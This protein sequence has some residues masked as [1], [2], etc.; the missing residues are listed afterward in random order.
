MVAVVRKRRALVTSVQEFQTRSGQVSRLVGV[1]Y[2]DA[3]GS[4]E[5]QLLWEREPINEV[6]EP[7]SPPNVESAPP[8]P[9]ADFN[10]V[11]RAA[12]WQALSPFV[13]ATDDG[14]SIR[15]WF[16]LTVKTGRSHSAPWLVPLT[17]QNTMP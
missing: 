16:I 8:M 17:S 5:D 3:D 13:H 12:R 6:I 10:A 15:L 4:R 2:L 9:P 11:E 1:E 14:Q 7:R